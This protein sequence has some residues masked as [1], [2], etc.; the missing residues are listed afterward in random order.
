MK[1][2]SLL[3]DSGGVLMKNKKIANRAIIIFFIA[4]SVVLIVNIISTFYREQLRTD[5]FPLKQMFPYLGNFVACYWKEKPPNMTQIRLRKGIRSYIIL[6]STKMKELEKD[7]SWR[8]ISSDGV[9]EQIHF[10]KDTRIPCYSC[11]EWWINSTFSEKVLQGDG[12]S[13][14]V[15]YNR[16]RG[17]VFIHATRFL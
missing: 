10:E 5:I 2:S 12:M 16:T 14:F 9:F 1:S 8:K 4:A 11:D 3:T 15:Y 17:V 13:G 7:F 6:D